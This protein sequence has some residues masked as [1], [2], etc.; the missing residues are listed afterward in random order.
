MIILTVL[1]GTIA[2]VCA[3]GWFLCSLSGRVLLCFMEKK[4]CPLPT[5]QE[6]KEC[7]REA[8]EKMFHSSRK[9]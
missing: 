5:R 7:S 8:V 9:K 4:G 6:L 1:L 2:V 3:A